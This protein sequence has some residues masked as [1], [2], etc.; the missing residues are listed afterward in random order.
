VRPLRARH[1]ERLRHVEHRGNG[2]EG[3]KRTIELH[4]EIEYQLIGA[5][6]DQIN[7]LYRRGKL[8]DEARRRIERELDLRDAQLTNLR[9]SD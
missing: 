1:H 8:K 4:D 5:E 3:H 7:D 2:D 6:R 9:S